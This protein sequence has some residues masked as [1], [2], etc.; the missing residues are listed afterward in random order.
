MVA[1]ILVVQAE[2]LL[3]DHIRLQELIP[4]NHMVEDPAVQDMEELQ[5]TEQVAVAALADIAEQAALAAQMLQVLQDLVAAVAVDIKVLAVE[6]DILVQ[7]QAAVLKVLQGP[8]E[9]VARVAG[10][11]DYLLFI[12]LDRLVEVVAVLICI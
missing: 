5:E 6:S 8:E 11:E 1:E 2:H 4:H 7:V 10:K 3:E 9:M 12:Q